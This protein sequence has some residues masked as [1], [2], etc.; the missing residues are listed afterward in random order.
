M[1][2][3]TLPKPMYIASQI[4]D[5][6]YQLGLG[7]RVIKADT[8]RDIMLCVAG[9]AVSYYVDECGNVVF[10]EDKEP[11]IIPNFMN[12]DTDYDKTSAI[13]MSGSEAI[14]ALLD[15]Y[16]CNTIRSFLEIEIPAVVFDQCTIRNWHDISYFFAKLVHRADR[17]RRL[18]S[19]EAPFV[20]MMNEE[21]IMN[22]ALQQLESN[23]GFATG[24]KIITRNDGTAL[25]SL[26]DV[27][28]SIVSGWSPEM[29]EYFEEEERKCNIEI[30]EWANQLTDGDY[31]KLMAELDEAAGKN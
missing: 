2:K 4:D 30:D 31:D 12:D 27:G 25:R 17:Y 16:K 8:I 1:L 18:A 11:V 5:I 15:H 20:I 13:L 7:G 19:L 3:V 9:V 24:G 26:A 10:R 21:K 23:D 14:T 28:Y 29:R 6:V 22:R